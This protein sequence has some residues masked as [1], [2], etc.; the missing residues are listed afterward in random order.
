MLMATN[1]FLALSP[2][3]FVESLG[4]HSLLKSC[5]Y[6]S[7]SVSSYALISTIG[8]FAVGAR[9]LPVFNKFIRDGPY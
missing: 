6:C 7:N 3:F 4:L 8:L 9:V 1:S 5:I 2:K